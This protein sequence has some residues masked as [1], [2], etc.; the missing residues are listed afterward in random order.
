[1]SG[2]DQTSDSG[3]LENAEAV[4]HLRQSVAAGRPW[5]ISLLEAI[6]LWTCPEERR[7]G[8]RYCYL[9]GGEAFDWVLLAERLAGEIAGSIPED[10]LSNLLFYG[11]LPEDITEDRFKALIGQ[12]KY[13][14]YLNYFY[15]VT[16][17]RFIILAVEE[18][19]EKERQA[20]VFSAREPGFEDSYR[21]VY[22]ATLEVL[23]GRFREDRGYGHDERIYIRELQE[24]T[25]WLFKY[26]VNN[27]DKERV[28]SDTRKGVECLRRKLAGRAI[29]TRQEEP[30]GKLMGLGPGW[31]PQESL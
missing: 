18:E 9:I 3:A 15:G 10:Q 16:V 26:R 17:E 8:E 6:G 7:N 2:G 4:I 19:I 21:R 31:Q 12:V 14:A 23:L 27:C 29:P 1:M 13:S 11:R 24:F 22:G 25:Y 20:H 28:A 5:H 30:D